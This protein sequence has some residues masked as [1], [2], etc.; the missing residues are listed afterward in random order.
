MHLENNY[1]QDESEYIDTF[2][3]IRNG[4]NVKR[5]INFSSA[6]CVVENNTKA[7]SDDY[8]ALASN[9]ELVTQ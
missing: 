8:I 3:A 5:T 9:S 4:E 2:E 6:K 7:I 1:R